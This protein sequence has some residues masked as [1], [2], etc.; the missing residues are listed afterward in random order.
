[1]K[2]CMEAI[3]RTHGLPEAVRNDNG[4]PFKFKEFKGFL[5]QS[6]PHNSGP[7][8]GGETMNDSLLQWL[9]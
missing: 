9:V 7:S 1:M 3:F 2:G 4:P 8:S 5:E 6:L